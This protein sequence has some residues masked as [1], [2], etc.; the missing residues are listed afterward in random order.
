MPAFA[1]LTLNDGKADQTFTPS[2]I[3]KND[4]AIFRNQ[5]SGIPVG[6]PSVTV[7]VAEATPGSSTGVARVKIQLAV[8]KLD[9]VT[10]SGA[11]ASTVSVVNTARCHMEFILPVQSTLAERN[12]IIA[13]A[14]AALANT[15][16]K[17]CAQNIEHFY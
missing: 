10:P 2:N 3:D 15:S 11:T 16:I 13:L 6:Y 14:A 1:A 5:A 9:T 8:P 4:V 12:A 7:S 17:S